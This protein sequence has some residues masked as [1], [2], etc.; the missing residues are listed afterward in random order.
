MTELKRDPFQIA[1]P[2]AGSATSPRL[3]VV[4]RGRMGGSLARAAAA[5]G[6]EVALA[7]RDGIP[8][9]CSGASAV[10]L[11]VPDTAI[12]GV[13]EELARLDPLPGSWGT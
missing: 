11:C 12:A 1:G 6:L 5:A 9:A 3:A 8:E 7:G 4:G 2:G 13:C 10:I